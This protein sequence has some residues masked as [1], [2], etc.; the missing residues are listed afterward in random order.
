MCNIC[1]VSITK[2]IVIYA[3]KSARNKRDGWRDRQ[4]DKQTYRQ[5]DGQADRQSDSK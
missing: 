4:A 1:N 5:A 3:K 2:K